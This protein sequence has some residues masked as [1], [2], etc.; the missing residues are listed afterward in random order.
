MF[1]PSAEGIGENILR[2]NAH[3]HMLS[4]NL[5][6]QRSEK[7]MNFAEAISKNSYN[8]GLRLPDPSIMLFVGI[9]LVGLAVWVKR[10][11]KRTAR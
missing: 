7:T 5:N 8:A 10:R 3:V 1:L 11:T 4:A 2:S 6:P 9:G